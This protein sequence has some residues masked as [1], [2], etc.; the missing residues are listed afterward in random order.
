MPLSLTLGIRRRALSILELV[1]HTY[2]AARI[3]FR[4]DPLGCGRPVAEARLQLQVFGKIHVRLDLSGS[5]R[6]VPRAD[7]H[8]AG[9]VP[10]RLDARA[11]TLSAAA[12]GSAAAADRE[13][14]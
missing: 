3:V 11:G 10:T 1:H 2:A 6:A 14:I 4:R 13:P 12:A 9:H 5:G 8:P 7:E